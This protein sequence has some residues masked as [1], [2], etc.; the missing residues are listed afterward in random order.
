MPHIRI[1]SMSVRAEPRNSET[2][3]LSIDDMNARNAPASRPERSAGSTTRRNVIHRDAPSTDEASSHAGS[4]PVAAAMALRS[5][6]G[7]TTM[8]C[9]TA[10]NVSE[11][12]KPSHDVNISAASPNA[13]PG[14][15]NGSMKPPSA[16]RVHL[17]GWRAIPSAAAVASTVAN[18]AA[19]TATIT[20]F[21]AATWMM[22]ELAGSNSSAYQ[23]S[24]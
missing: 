1:G 8:P 14:R 18:A 9:A 20:L 19:S 11:G 15:I 16:Q 2:G 3:T 4:S 5:T 10:T 23:R 12:V 22:C 7:V 24:V 17:A 21:R 6:Y 13:M